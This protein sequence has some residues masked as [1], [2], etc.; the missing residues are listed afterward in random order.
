[1]ENTPTSN[2]KSHWVEVY[3]IAIRSSVIKCDCIAFRKLKS[4]KKNTAQKPSHDAVAYLFVSKHKSIFYFQVS[5]TAARFDVTFIDQY[6]P[7]SHQRF[8]VKLHKIR[9]EQCTSTLNTNHNRHFA[10]TSSKHLVFHI[11]LANEYNW[12]NFSNLCQRALCNCATEL[13]ARTTHLLKLEICERWHRKKYLKAILFLIGD[14]TT[15]TLTSSPIVKTSLTSLIRARAI[16]LIW[17]I[18]L[19]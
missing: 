18:P 8:K 15:I 17:R 1:M 3:S 5:R 7:M 16:L 9:P 12:H 10:I 13:L 4:T 19:Q 14:V 6:T 11:W 2:G